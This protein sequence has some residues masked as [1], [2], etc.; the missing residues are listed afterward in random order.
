MQED[1]GMHTTNEFATVLLATYTIESELDTQ[2]CMDINWASSRVKARSIDPNYTTR[3][4]RQCKKLFMK[5]D[6]EM[7]KYLN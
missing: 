4:I 5:I 6:L 2:S 1:V 3:K 7:N